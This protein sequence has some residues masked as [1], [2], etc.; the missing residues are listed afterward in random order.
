MNPNFRKSKIIQKTN[1]RTKEI[2]YQIL[3]ISLEISHI[4]QLGIGWFK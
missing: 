1:L 2:K 3:S 4:F